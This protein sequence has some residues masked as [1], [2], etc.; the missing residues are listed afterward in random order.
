MEGSMISRSSV[1]IRATHITLMKCLIV[2]VHYSGT[3]SA[4]KQARRRH[5]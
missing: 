1:R 5:S 2:P 4:K 3:S